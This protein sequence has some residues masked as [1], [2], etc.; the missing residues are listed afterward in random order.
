MRQ[1]TRGKRKT[2]KQNL[3]GDSAHRQC[4]FQRATTQTKCG[5]Q[6]R[7]CKLAQ[8]IS[9]RAR[10][11]GANARAGTIAR[12]VN[13]SKHLRLLNAHSSVSTRVFFSYTCI[14][15]D[16]SG[17]GKKQSTGSCM[18]YTGSCLNSPEEKEFAW[19]HY[20]IFR[21]TVSRGKFHNLFFFFLQPTSHHNDLKNCSDEE[22]RHVVSC[23]KNTPLSND[24]QTKK[25]VKLSILQ[26]I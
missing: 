9:R 10:S 25:R 5:T 19:A 16:V 22:C 8:Q 24:K 12:V 20:C 4:S 21:I 14:H 23:L 1:W 7:F 3:H 6:T 13:F 2:S 18:L 26:E 11:R 15:S 17:A